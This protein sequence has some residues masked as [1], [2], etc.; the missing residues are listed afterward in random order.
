MA[1]ARSVTVSA[2][3]Q[4]LEVSGLAA[5]LIVLIAVHAKRINLLT[6]GRVVGHVANGK[7]HLEFRES[8]E[9]VRFVE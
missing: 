1:Q 4:R 6:V 7:V 9:P 5:A 3:G 8:S 2:A